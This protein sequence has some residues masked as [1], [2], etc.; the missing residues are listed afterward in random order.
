MDRFAIA[1]ATL[2]AMQVLPTPPFG[3][4]TTIRRPGSPLRVAGVWALRVTEPASSSPTRSTDWCRLASP[5]ITT[6]SRAGAERLLEHVGRQL[7]HR[8]HRADLGMRS[9]EPVH[10][11]EAHG[12]H[13]AGTE[14]GHDGSSRRQF[15]DEVFDR[16]ELGGVGQLDGESRPERVVRLDDREVEVG[17]LDAYEA[18]PWRT[19]PL[20]YRVPLAGAAVPPLLEPSFGGSSTR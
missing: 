17:S 13:E 19:T 18:R 6:A 15:L 3:E 2:I 9:R 4:K 8:E 11:L 1:T 5:P 14:H 16:L 20:A 12:A 10:V 7:A